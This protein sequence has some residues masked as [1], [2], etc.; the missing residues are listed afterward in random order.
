MKKELLTNFAQNYHLKT[1]K[2]PYKN[3]FWGIA[4]LM[5]IPAIVSI[6]LQITAVWVTGLC[7]SIVALLV[8]IFAKKIGDYEVLNNIGLFFGIGIFYPFVFLMFSSRLLENK[9]III[10]IALADFIF[11]ITV[12]LFYLKWKIS[13]FKEKDILLEKRFSNSKLFGGGAISIVGLVILVLL[14]RHIMEGMVNSSIGFFLV[15]LASISII[16]GIPFLVSSTTQFIILKKYKL[17][18]IPKI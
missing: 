9:S 17:H 7:L 6:R 4:V 8:S 2:A 16:S 1:I 18:I 12:S 10:F 11:G 13:K 14:T 5:L 15:A 3:K